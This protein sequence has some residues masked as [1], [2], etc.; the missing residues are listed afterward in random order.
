MA[1][2]RADLIRRL[3]NRDD[4]ILGGSL[5][6]AYQAG[7]QADVAFHAEAAPPTC[8]DRID[9]LATKYT[10]QAAER[11]S[12][13]VGDD[14]PISIDRA[15]LHG[16]FQE[17]GLELAAGTPT[18]LPKEEAEKAVDEMFRQKLSRYALVYANKTLRVSLMREIAIS[19]YM[20]RA[21]PSHAPTPHDT[22]DY[23][24]NRIVDYCPRCANTHMCPR[25]CSEA[26]ASAP[27]TCPTCN[28]TG[29]VLNP[30]WTTRNNVYRKWIFCPK[31]NKGTGLQP[32]AEG[33]KK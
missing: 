26:K 32:S 1:E 30:T 12:T 15:W 24:A 22:V 5:D 11:S 31:C 20:R 3:L 10:N 29:L 2:T 14:D 19:L 23:R 6:E 18:Q 21:S 17:M 8:G 25:D 27:P 16:L 13:I 7:Y 33:G 9:V 28:D 4:V